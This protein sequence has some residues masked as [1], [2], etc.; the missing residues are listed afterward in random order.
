MAK[1]RPIKKGM[2][3]T[4]RAGGKRHAKFQPYSISGKSGPLKV[5]QAS[6]LSPAE[7]E[8]YGL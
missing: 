8:K 1:K 3:A 7:R 5:K 4:G 2:R 6:D